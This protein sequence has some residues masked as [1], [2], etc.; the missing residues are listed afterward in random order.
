[1]P[2]L[3]T[4]L[5]VL[6]DI[7]RPLPSLPSTPSLKEPLALLNLL[8]RRFA[9]V[10]V[11]PGAALMLPDTLAVELRAAG[12][13]VSDGLRTAIVE[14]VAEGYLRAREE[15][16]REETV[17]AFAKAIPIALVAPRCLSMIVGGPVPAELVREAVEDLGRAFLRNDARS[18]VIDVE[19][20]VDP[21][22][23]V[24]AELFAA[25]DVGATMGVKVVFAAPSQ[26][27]LDA[28]RAS[29]VQ[30]DSLETAPTYAEAL[31]SALLAA[32]LVL[33]PRSRLRALVG[34]E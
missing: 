2:E 5:D 31:R 30:V 34:A 26:A 9:D 12:W 25:R 4:L 13:D 19:R 32:G 11:T 20:L 18:V 6:L 14:V 17:T 22:P 21:T 1:Q 23:A 7:P 3:V 15:R 16:A 8:A 10:G 27:L 33:R 29:H 28:A 24:A